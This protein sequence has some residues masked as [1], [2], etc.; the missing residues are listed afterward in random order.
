MATGPGL[1]IL[2]PGFELSNMILQQKKPVA[3]YAYQIDPVQVPPVPPGSFTINGITDV[4]ALN[5][6]QLLVTERSFS[7]GYANNN[8]RIYVAELAA[9][10]DI[11]GINSLKENNVSEQSFFPRHRSAIAY[12]LDIGLQQ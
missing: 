9:A 11:S 1:K 8:I 12:T 4:L 7:T 5:D 2:L 3:Q 10:E 6:H